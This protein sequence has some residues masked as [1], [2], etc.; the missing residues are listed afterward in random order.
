MLTILKTA[1]RILEGLLVLIMSTLVL[2]VLWGVIGRFALNAP[3][4]WTEEVATYLL[5][6]LSL[7]GAVVA[8]ERNEHLGVD[9]LVKKLDD[10]NHLIVEILTLVVIILFCSFVLI[11]GGSILVSETLGSGQLTPALGIKMGYV[12]SVVPVTGI[13]FV[14]VACARIGKLWTSENSAKA[15]EHK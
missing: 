5:V 12:Y 3:P 1:M 10:A 14:A 2:V 11:F 7:L 13:L 6:W 8:F 4:R 9:Y 15:E